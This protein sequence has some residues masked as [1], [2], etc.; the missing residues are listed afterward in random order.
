MLKTLG[1]E[2]VDALAMF[3]SWVAHFDLSVREYKFFTCT[4]N[5]LRR[6]A[7][8]L[9]QVLTSRSF[10]V[11]GWMPFCMWNFKKPAYQ[12]GGVYIRRYKHIYVYALDQY[13]TDQ[14]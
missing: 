5:V 7:S 4:A 13:S 8:V 14:Y 9:A 2:V 3:I 1:S 12:S 6:Y 10:L 11:T